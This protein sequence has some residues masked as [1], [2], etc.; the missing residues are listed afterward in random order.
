MITTATGPRVVV[1]T[2]L[3]IPVILITLA[4]VPAVSLLPVLSEARARRVFA[5]AQV[6]R[7][8]HCD[9]AAQISGRWVP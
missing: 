5:F 1:G 7:T 3:L 9:L 4:V 6:C 8:W 2:L